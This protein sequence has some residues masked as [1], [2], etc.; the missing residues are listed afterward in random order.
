MGGLPQSLVPGPFPASGPMS[1][2]GGG[3]ELPPSPVQSPVPGPARG[4]IPLVTGPDQSPV[5]GPAW[6]GWGYPSQDRTGVHPLL[7]PGTG[8]EVP[9]PRTGWGTPTGQDKGYPLDMMEV[10]PRQDK[11]YPLDMMEVPPPPQTGQGV[12]LCRGQYAFCGHKEELSC[13]LILQ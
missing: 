8:Q 7:P 3:A 4:G 2:L 5:L 1:F 6:E 12:M 9:P 13:C 10:P 11:G